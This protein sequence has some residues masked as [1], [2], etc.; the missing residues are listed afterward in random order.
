MV[1]NLPISQSSSGGTVYIDKA[2]GKQAETIFFTLK[3]Y[4][5]HTLVECMP[6]TG[7]MHQIRIHLNCLNTPII[8]DPQYGGKEIYLSELKRK[9]NLKEGTEELPLIKRVALHAYSLTYNSLQNEQIEVVAEYPKD[10]RVLIKKLE[11]LS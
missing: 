8:G 10:F 4:K 6:I 7:R 9:F 11:E 1:V 5:N 3:V 2:E